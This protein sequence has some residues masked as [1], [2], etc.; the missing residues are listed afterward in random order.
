M[1]R[2]STTVYISFES[3][4]STKF[5]YIQKEAPKEGKINL[6]DDGHEFK[7]RPF[8]KKYEN[9]YKALPSD[10]S[11]T[12]E[13]MVATKYMDLREEMNPQQP[14]SHNTF[15]GQ[16]SIEFNNKIFIGTG[17]II[18]M[19]MD[20]Q[21]GYILTCA[22]NVVN[23][24]KIDKK[25][26]LYATNI[27]FTLK[28]EDHNDKCKFSIIKSFV[29]PP[30]W[31]DPTPESGNDAAICLFKFDIKDLDKE[32]K[33]IIDNVKHASSNSLFYDYTPTNSVP[34]S[35]EC[36]ELIGFSADQT[37]E[38]WGMSVYGGEFENFAED[39]NYKI[40]YGPNKGMNIKDKLI[41]YTFIDTSGGQSG[42]PLMIFTSHRWG[43]AGIHCGGSEISGKNYSTKIRKD[44]I[45][46]IAHKLNKQ[47]K[48]EWKYNDYVRYKLYKKK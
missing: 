31:N 33:E 9:I 41:T 26:K 20:K 24:D 14:L 16:M 34:N 47:L 48:E 6:E 10:T 40:K 2:L 29:Y 1:T 44:L 11:Q 39:D 35:I 25:T 38:M 5:K 15:I 21:I 7:A 27:W 28:D 4:R 45:Q 19:D 30:Y 23:V 32:Q 13:V 43:I 3:S 12:A 42:S 17:Q 18:D 37:G 36:I 46:W 8:P 22:H